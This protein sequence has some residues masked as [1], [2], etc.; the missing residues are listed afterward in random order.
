[1]I[2]VETTD[3][4]S[5]AGSRKDRTGDG[6]PV[7][8][9]DRRFPCVS[10]VM[11]YYNEIE[12]LDMAPHCLAIQRFHDFE[13]ILVD[14]ASTDGTTKAIL[15]ESS[16][17]W[18]A[19]R[20]VRND[21]RK[22]LRRARNIG[23][24]S[25]SASI[26]VTLDFHTIFD[27]FFL[28]R[29][30]EAYRSNADAAVVGSLV[31]P[32]PQ[33]WHQQ[34]M[35]ALER[36]LARLR[37]FFPSYSYV[38][39]GAA[40]YRASVLRALGGLSECE[41]VEDV[42]FCYR[43]TKAGFKIIFLPEN[44]VYHREKRG[45]YS[46]LKRLFTTGIDAARIVMTHKMQII[47]PQ[48]TVRLL[49]VPLLIAS[50]LYFPLGTLLVSPVLIVIYLILARHADC[51]NTWKELTYSLLVLPIFALVTWIGILSGFIYP[52]VKSKSRV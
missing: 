31:L 26:I 35:R 19:Y 33:G 27:E 43:A 10:V 2:S 25:A 48:Y 11:N 40:S 47:S 28:E 20:L 34:G 9:D 49:S 37:H 21:H 15:K 8:G 38:F 7:S 3:G 42:D 23:V 18:P 12:N 51:R 22:G 50:I 13:V 45:F 44:V 6:Q 52:V 29:I 16:Q 17:R 1:M 4:K 32:L 41:V 30:V 24:T 5:L 46:F 14:D 39:G 36:T